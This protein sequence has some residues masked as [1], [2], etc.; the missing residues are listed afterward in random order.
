MGKSMAEKSDNGQRSSAWIELLKL[1]PNLLW[2]LLAI[3]GFLLFSRTILAAIEQR[4]ISEL[5]IGVVQLK[6]SNQAADIAQIKI[7]KGN[8][9]LLG[10][11]AFEPV[12]ERFKRI[13]KQV[14]GANVLWV[15]DKPL[16]CNL[17]ERRAMSAYGLRI[18]TA[19]STKEA[20]DA[21]SAANYN[22]D[23]VITNMSREDDYP[24]APCFSKSPGDEISNPPLDDAGARRS[25]DARCSNVD[26]GD[27]R[28]NQKPV[29]NFP[30]PTAA[31][32][33][34]R[35]IRESGEKSGKDIPVIVYLTEIHPD[36]GTPAF[37]VGIT[38]RPDHLAQ[39]V[40]DALERRKRPQPSLIQELLDNATL[41][42]QKLRDAVGSG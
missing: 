36:W 32:Y 34:A 29:I 2:V 16:S 11:K 23:V 39:F 8:D 19:R 9:T 21:L 26:P 14:M 15:D 3:V 7:E 4:E 1:I 18:D 42:L 17:Y 37:T 13:A 5:N 20:L 35:Q 6:L 33:L 38:R 27:Q 41:L 12:N 28:S 40:F 10:S 25:N 24:K 22:Y 31:C 30:T